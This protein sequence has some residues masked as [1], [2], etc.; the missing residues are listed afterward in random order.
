MGSFY[1]QWSHFATVKPFAWAEQYNLAGAPNRQVRRRMEEEN[2]KARR[3][4]RREFNDKVR[5]VRFSGWLG[6]W[7]PHTY[8]PSSLPPFTHPP[9]PQ[10]RDTLTP[11]MS[12]CALP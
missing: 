7:F 8:C 1:A 9:S 6:R 5:G 2:R 3:T 10:N 11:S 4:A 12:D